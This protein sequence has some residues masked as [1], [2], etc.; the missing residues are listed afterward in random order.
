MK[1]KD[2][3]YSRFVDGSVFSKFADDVA[4]L[5]NEGDVKYK[6]MDEIVSSFLGPSWYLGNIMKYSQRM[7]ANGMAG[8]RVKLRRD[9]A[10]IAAY[11]FLLYRTIEAEEQKEAK[12]R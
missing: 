9:A 11:A 12:A 7:L 2:L 8:G 3:T 4:D 10:K 6:A 5:L 1:L